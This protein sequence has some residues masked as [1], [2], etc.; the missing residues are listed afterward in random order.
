MAWL[1]FLMEPGS[2]PGLIRYSNQRPEDNLLILFDHRIQTLFNDTHQNMF[3]AQTESTDDYKGFP[4]YTSQKVPLTELLAIINRGGRKLGK[5]KGHVAWTASDLNDHDTNPPNTLYQFT[6]EE[7]RFACIK[8]A[9]LGRLFYEGPILEDVDEYVNSTEWDQDTQC[10]FYQTNDVND[11]GHVGMHKT[12]IFPEQRIIWRHENEAAFAKF[13]RSYKQH[14]SSIFTADAEDGQP[15]GFAAETLFKVG[16]YPEG[17]FEEARKSPIWE[18]I[19]PIDVAAAQE[20]GLS[21]RTSQFFRNLAFRLGRTIRHYHQLQQ[22][23]AKSPGLSRKELKSASEK[24]REM[25]GDVKKT[26]KLAG[27]TPARFTT[28]T[29][30]IPRA[31]PSHPAVESRDLTTLFAAFRKGLINDSVQNYTQTY[32]SRPTFSTDEKG[33]VVKT[34]HRQNVWGWSEK[35]I[36]E[37]H[38]PYIRERYFDVRRWPLHRQSEATQ[39]IIRTRKDENLCIQSPLAWYRYGIRVGPAAK[40]GTLS[41][42]NSIIDVL[43]SKQQQAAVELVKKFKQALVVSMR[44]ANVSLSDEWELII[45]PPLKDPWRLLDATR[46]LEPIVRPTSKFIPGPASFPMG[47]TLLKQI[48][49]SQELESIL[50]PQPQNLGAKLLNQFTSWFAPEPDRIPLLPEIDENRAPRSNPRK[51]RL[52][53]AFLSELEPAQKVAALP[54][55]LNDRTPVRP[56]HHTNVRGPRVIESGRRPIPTRAG[57]STS[58]IAHAPDSAE[59]KEHNRREKVEAAAVLLRGKVIDQEEV[60]AEAA[61]EAPA[62]PEW[63]VK[64]KPHNIRKADEVPIVEIVRNDDGAAATTGESKEAA[65]KKAAFDLVGGKKAEEGYVW[66]ASVRRPRYSIVQDDGREVVMIDQD[67]LGG[68]EKAVKAPSAQWTATEVAPPNIILRF[69]PSEQIQKGGFKPL[70]NPLIELTDKESDYPVP[71][72]KKPAAPVFTFGTQSPAGSPLNRRVPGSPLDGRASSSVSGS[73][74]SSGPRSSTASAASTVVVPTQGSGTGFAPVSI[75]EITPPESEGSSRPESRTQDWGEWCYLPF[76]PVDIKGIP[77]TDAN[78]KPRHQ[79]IRAWCALQTAAFPNGYRVVPTPGSSNH[80]GVYAMVISMRRQYPTMRG[81]R[82]VTYEKLLALGTDP[83][84]QARLADIGGN[85]ATGGFDASMNFSI[86][87]LTAML[88]GWGTKVGIRLHLGIVY[89]MASRR[90][91]FVIL[92]EQPDKADEDYVVWIHSA[93][94]TVRGRREG[95]TDAEII[96]EDEQLD[97]TVYNHFSGIMPNPPPRSS[98][99]LKGR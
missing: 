10:R 1:K 46:A 43:P 25:V 98:E 74:T 71:V 72:K 38:A 17:G 70:D 80:C 16:T 8:L 4:S 53:S 37:H 49:I 39:K 58:N 59:E 34:F 23:S 45:N 30:V 42:E 65:T 76:G 12:E 6:L 11:W 28:V 75:A 89:P 9:R 50:D 36:R 47:D 87:I 29:D 85:F 81:V 15:D 48:Q 78:G 93:D 19:V 62:P 7:A 63:K 83:R 51:R 33:H 90:D 40:K 67:E 99:R 91:P 5:E 57:L 55:P 44:N 84:V 41:Y 32:P 82:E 13:N 97:R 61:V 73:T 69:N 86:D 54:N 20:L 18:D 68:L 31:S 3:W 27:Y 14:T 60:V 94:A 22:R 79:T 92:N 96:A 2:A 88:E 64:S 95:M 35:V 77:D 26:A 21:E 66:P 52:P 56:P 24:W